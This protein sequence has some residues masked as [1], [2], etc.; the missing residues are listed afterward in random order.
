[1]SSIQVES[2]DVGPWDYDAPKLY[3]S[4]SEADSNQ[5]ESTVIVT[6]SNADVAIE[7]RPVGASRR[8][9]TWEPSQGL[10]RGCLQQRTG[11]LAPAMCGHELEALGWGVEPRQPLGK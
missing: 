7:K 2:A 9:G 11:A 6:L 1:M 5:L 8:I 4:L 10:Q 3:H